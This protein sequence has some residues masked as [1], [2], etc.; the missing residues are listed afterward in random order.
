MII[1]VLA[2]A[3]SKKEVIILK[4]GIYQVFTKAPATEGK[5]NKAIISLLAEYFD[6]PKSSI[7][8]KVGKKSKRKLV[9]IL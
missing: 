9:E 7:V 5:A 8:I 3:N 4:D 1:N 6:I 2:K